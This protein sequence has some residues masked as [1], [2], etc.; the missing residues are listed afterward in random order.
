MI[1]SFRRTPE[2]SYSNELDTGIRRRD[3]IEQCRL[4]EQPKH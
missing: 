3:G 1:L 4:P 2:S